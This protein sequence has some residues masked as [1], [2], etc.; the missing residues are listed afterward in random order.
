MRWTA[1]TA[2]SFKVLM[3][4]VFVYALWKGRWEERVVA[5]TAFVAT[6]ATKLV[7]K[8]MHLRYRAVEYPIMAIDFIVVAILVAVALRSDRYWPMWAAGFALMGFLA[9]FM[10]LAMPDLSPFVYAFAVACWGW[11]VLALLLIGTWRVNRANNRASVAL[12]Q[13]AAI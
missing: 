11:G 7:T 9:H 13:E 1:I 2:L 3:V 8:P 12:E 5:V 6:F 10:K 4:L